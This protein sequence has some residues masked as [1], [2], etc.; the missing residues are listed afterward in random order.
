MKRNTL[1]FVILLS[2]ILVSAFDSFVPA[3]EMSGKYLKFK[4]CYQKLFGDFDGGF[5][6]F[7]ISI[8]KPYIYKNFAISADFQ[9]KGDGVLRDLVVNLTPGIT[10]NK[11][12]TLA[13]S[14]GFVQRS[15]DTGELVFT[16][17]EDIADDNIRKPIIGLSAYSK[18]FKERVALS[19]AFYH[20]NQP[21]T[22]FIG[23]DD[24]HPMKITAGLDWKISNIF[25]LGTFFLQEDEQNYFGLQFKLK[26]P[27][28][29]FQHT[30]RISEEKI[31][32]RP[33]FHTL[34]YWDIML[35]YNYYMESNELGK[36]NYGICL[37][38]QYTGKDKPELV[39]YDVPNLTDDETA[40]ISFEIL[41][42]ERLD[43]VSVYNGDEL[44]YEQQQIWE[45]ES[46][47]FDISVPLNVG[48]NDIKIV[49][50]GVNNQILERDYFIEREPEAG[51][52][53]EEEPEKVEEIDE[54][55]VVEEEEPDAVI[56]AVEQD[57]TETTIGTF[58]DASFYYSVI[59]G[60][61]LWN[62]AK[63]PETYNNA[64][65]WKL[66]YENNSDMIENPDLIYPGQ[67]FYIIKEKEDDDVS[68]YDVEKG[69][70]LWTIAEKE[71][72]FGNGR[73]WKVIYLVNKDKIKDPDVI[74][75]GQKLKIIKRELNP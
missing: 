59:K 45:Y 37:S 61:N 69:D 4:T 13:F 55:E 8:A 38:Y 72:I 46:K 31:S 71:E 36:E 11:K 24:K 21:E 62:I 66:I 10:F 74:F 63:K 9:S 20:I 47:R 17:D 54:E 25:N 39:I 14:T 42:P 1:L 34:N 33:S 27:A 28:P 2:V 40:N 19:C 3:E 16:E 52:I 18:F 26:F 15:L 29:H 51:P 35:G 12:F 60:D 5:N 22:S 68:Y 56:I 32:Y 58:D 43:Y 75:P 30:F 7:G 64:W 6:N 65:K 57:E 50:Q 44:V 67:K 49:V 41:E 73:K 23:S 53:V 70:C 48:I